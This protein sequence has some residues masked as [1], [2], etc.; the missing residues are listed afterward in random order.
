MCCS[1]CSADDAVRL[2][3]L[4]LIVCRQNNHAQRAKVG[5]RRGGEAGQH[6]LPLAH[7]RCSFVAACVLAHFAHVA[8]PT[9]CVAEQKV[10]DKEGIPPDQQRLIFKAKELEDGRTLNSHGIQ[11]RAT[12]HLLLRLQPRGPPEIGQHQIFVKTITGQAALKALAS[13]ITLLNAD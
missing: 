12:L 7:A 6:K 4:S 2:T 13:I 8:S 3:L 5:H 9:A 1:S 10:Q 11:N